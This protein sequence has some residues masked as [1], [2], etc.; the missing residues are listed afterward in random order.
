MNSKPA[1]VEKEEKGA[2]EKDDQS[3][4]GAS[5]LISN[6]FQV[7]VRGACPLATVH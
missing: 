1:V 2:N 6:D 3:M 7:E 4:S 5:G